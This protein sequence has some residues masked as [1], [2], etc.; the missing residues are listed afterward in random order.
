MQ[1]MKMNYKKGDD[2]YLRVGEMR[3]PIDP[4]APE[5][6][7]RNVMA[8]AGMITG[9]S[10]SLLAGLALGA[11]ST[12][13]IVGAATAGL[14]TGAVV[15][16]S[17]MEDEKLNGRKI[18]TNPTIFNNCM[19]VG[20]AKGYLPSL[21]VA[22]IATVAGAPFLSAIAVSIPVVTLGSGLLKG[23]VTKMTM[24][25]TL[26][27]F[28]GKVLNSNEEE[29][30]KSETKGK[31]YQLNPEEVAHLKSRLKHGNGNNHSFVDALEAQKSAGLQQGK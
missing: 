4:H 30:M 10:V 25:Q 29:L 28:N 11:F 7:Y 3:A 22:A 18:M 16:K 24:Q 2:G 5:P 27:K 31:P 19:A 12:P 9:I 1:K 14:A 17:Q 15:G 21:A 20:I 6:R 23:L 13:L 26:N 8:A